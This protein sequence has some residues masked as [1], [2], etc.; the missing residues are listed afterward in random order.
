MPEEIQALIGALQNP[1][2]ERVGLRDYHF[3]ALHGVECVMVYSRI[4]KVAA[5]STATQLIDRFKVSEVLFTGLAGGVGPGVR[6]GDIVIGSELIQHDLDASPLFPRH[7]VPLLGVTRF[8]AHTSRT[9][10]LLRSAREFA[11]THGVSVHQGLIA[12]GDQF[13]SSREA[14][15]RLRAAIPDTL[16]VEMEGAAVAQICHEHGVPFSIA[17]TIS[18]SANEQAPLD[19][20]Q[21]LKEVAGPY[22]LGVV[23]QYLKTPHAPSC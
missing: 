20:P 18:D 17:R 16:C 14:V 15:T 8:R 21:F 3:G 2:I 1:R 10:A 13:F 4:G 19:F 12:S 6:R 9:E 22:A 11:S 7:E 23:G 5:A